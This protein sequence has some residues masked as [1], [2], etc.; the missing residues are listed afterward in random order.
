[1]RVL[2]ETDQVRRSALD[3]CRPSHGCNGW[4]YWMNENNFKTDWTETSVNPHTISKVFYWHP[5]FT[6]LFL[7]FLTNILSLHSSH[8]HRP[9]LFHPP[10][11]IASLPASSQPRP[12]VLP[13]APIIRGHCCFSLIPLRMSVCM[14]VCVCAHVRVC[15]YCSSTQHG[16][17][18][19]VFTF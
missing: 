1:M 12:S 18:F 17:P 8:F 16:N 10:L 11:L 14:R 6:R 7:T 4:C 13:A 19:S 5:P 9:D 3:E 15:V 2:P